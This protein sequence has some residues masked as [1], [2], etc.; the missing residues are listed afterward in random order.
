MGWVV[1]KH[2]DVVRK[3]AAR[4][5]NRPRSNATKMLWTQTPEEFKEEIGRT[6][7]LLQNLSGQE[8]TTFR[9]PCFSMTQETFWA[10]PILA[11]L[12]F[13]IDKSPW[14]RRPRQQWRRR[15]SLSATLF[16]RRSPEILWSFR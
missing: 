4:P 3:I 13:K 1:E 15:R 5:R 7:K 10:Y 2:P 16:C 14:F 11:E 6:R 9:A 8:V 12:G